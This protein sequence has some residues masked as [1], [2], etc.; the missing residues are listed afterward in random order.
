MISPGRN[1]SESPPVLVMGWGGLLQSQRDSPLLKKKK[2]KK[3]CTVTVE[4][5][6]FCRCYHCMISEYGDMPKEELKLCG[7][8]PGLHAECRRIPGSTPDMMF[9]RAK[10]KKGDLCLRAEIL[11]H[12]PKQCRFPVQHNRVRFALTRLDPLLS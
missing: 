5:P 6:R 8:V 11:R 9:S 2:P 10:A 4:K 3:P 7:R 12:R 1:Q